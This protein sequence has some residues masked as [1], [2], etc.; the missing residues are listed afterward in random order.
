MWNAELIRNQSDV[1]NSNDWLSLTGKDRKVLL[2]ECRWNDANEYPQ[3][4]ML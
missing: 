2:I 4:E 3:Y 1:V